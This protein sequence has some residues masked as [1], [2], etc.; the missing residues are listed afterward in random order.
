M[1]ER[2][3]KIAQQ[4]A[5]EII[6]NGQHAMENVLTKE[7]DRLDELKKVNANICRGQ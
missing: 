2:C 5:S 3:K 7:V 6:K 1:L 4:Q